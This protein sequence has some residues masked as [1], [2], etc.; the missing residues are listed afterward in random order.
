MKLDFIFIDEAQFFAKT[1]FTPVLAALKPGAQ[2]F[3]AADPTQGFLKRHQSWLA[4]GIEVRGRAT[5]LAIPYRSTRAILGFAVGL[6]ENRRSRD[7]AAVPAD[8]DPPTGAEI[9]A[10]PEM[11][12]A[13][14]VIATASAQDS[15]VAAARAVAHLLQQSPG[16]AGHVLLL[17]ANSHATGDLV[18]VLR[19]HLGADQV[20]DL[21]D[22]RQPAPAAPCCAVSNLNAATGLEAAAVFLLGIDQLLASEADPRLDADARTELAA[23][24][25][26]LLYM[27]A[28]R[29]ARR[30][31][32][33]SPTPAV[34]EWLL[35][36]GAVRA[37]DPPGRL[38]PGAI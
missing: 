35:G 10:I 16:L 20:T 3:L 12:E 9:A 32:I 22:A 7:P 6:L 33:F 23:D 38:K 2:L 19:R 31:V 14:W 29:A 17:H 25:T 27:A 8:L 34:T 36:I 4:A 18:A 37:E 26:R 13:P 24:H 21:G 30:L 5:R 15:L 1:W 28:T 11:G